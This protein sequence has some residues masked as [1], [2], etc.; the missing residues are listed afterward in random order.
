MSGRGGHTG[1]KSWVGLDVHD[2]AGAFPL[3]RLLL[4][5]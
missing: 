1:E 2:A 4:F 5:R 3:A